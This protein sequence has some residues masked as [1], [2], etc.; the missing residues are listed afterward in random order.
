M[1]SRDRFLW[2]ASSCK[3]QR[4]RFRGLWVYVGGKLSHDTE[5]LVVISNAKSDLFAD[6]RLRWKTKTLFQALKEHGFELE[7][8]HLSQERRSS[9]WFGFLA[10]GP[11]W[12]LKVGQRLEQ[13]DPLPLKAHRRRVVSVFRH[14]WE[15]L[16]SLISCLVGRPCSGSFQQAIEQL[17]P[18]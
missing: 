13:S 11:C 10:L 7:A 9:G 1:K 8:C 4:M 12:C 18:I 17:C 5:F 6:Y 3:P 15:Q 16:Q 14:G 2:R